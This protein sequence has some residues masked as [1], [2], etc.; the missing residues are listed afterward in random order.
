MEV[1]GTAIMAI[2]EFFR[3]VKIGIPKSISKKDAMT[4][5]PIEWSL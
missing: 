2:R 5:Y 4:G 1:N 3:N